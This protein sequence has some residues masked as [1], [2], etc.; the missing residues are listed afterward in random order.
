VHFDAHF[1][2]LLAT[3]AASAAAPDNLIKLYASLRAWAGGGCGRAGQG[4]MG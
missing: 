4:V 1:S 2:L 3:E